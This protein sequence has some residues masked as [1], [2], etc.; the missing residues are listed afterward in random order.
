M[1]YYA[2]AVNTFNGNTVGSYLD[3]ATSGGISGDGFNTVATATMLISDVPN[4]GG[5]PWLRIGTGAIAESPFVAWDKTRVGQLTSFYGAMDLHFTAIPAASHRIFTPVGNGLSRGGVVVTSTQ[6]LRVIDA[7]GSTIATTTASFPLN[8]PFWVEWYWVG[9][10]TVG[11]WIARL[12]SSTSSST[13]LETITTA[14]SLNLGGYADKFRY[15]S[16]AGVSNMT[17]WYAKNVR[18]DPYAWPGLFDPYNQTIVDNLCIADTG[19]PEPGVPDRAVEFDGIGQYVEIPNHSALSIAATGSF[20]TMALVR[21]TSLVMPSAQDG[22]WDQNLV[23]WYGKG[24]PGQ[25]EYVGR[26]YQLGNDENRSNR[27]SNYAFNLSGGLGNGSYFQDAIAVGEWILIIGCWDAT[28]VAIYRDGVK[29]D[30]DLLDQHASSPVGPVVTPTAGTAPLRIGTRDLGSFFQGQIGRFAVFSRRLSDVEITGLQTSRLAGTLDATVSGL[31]GLVGFWKLNEA[32][33]AIAAV[34]SSGNGH[35]GT[36]ALPVAGSAPGYLTTQLEEAPV[37]RG[38]FGGTAA[39]YVVYRGT[40]DA[41]IMTG[42]ATGTA[43]DA[44]TGGSQYTDLLNMTGT[45][46]TSFPAA[47]G[48]GDYPFGVVEQLQGP[49][50]VGLELPPLSMWVEI[51]PAG[52]STPL[53]RQQLVASNAAEIA[54]ARSSPV[55]TLSWPVGASPSTGQIENRKYNNYGYDL[56]IVGVAYSLD[57][58]PTGA[59]STAD[60]Y[61]NGTTIFG[62]GSLPV[63]ASGGHNTGMV[64][65]ATVT[66][67]AAGSYLTARL[68]TVNS[69]GSGY[70]TVTCVRA[71]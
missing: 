68:N 43:W 38:L 40:G 54:A 12:Y 29:R 65:T 31:S 70:I 63:I 41:A 22:A 37:A 47:D 8:T 20:T 53:P 16:S 6:K 60:I 23:H 9:S 50:S 28:N 1:T 44:Q 66:T 64:T 49:P 11:Q 34:D 58:A 2:P 7:A 48:T 45:P 3:P 33:G 51:T 36:Y 39:D 27:F 5:E 17:N 32:D 15:G 14:A 61:L 55:I 18:L 62:G 24:E 4:P 69:G 21:P 35:H 42:G 59:G 25:H 30:E 19:L 71:A 13:P 10:A 26:M 67:L 57:T 46:I 56:E 52:S